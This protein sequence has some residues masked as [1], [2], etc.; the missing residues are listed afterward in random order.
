MSEDEKLLFIKHLHK[1]IKKRKK[2]KT[3]K[4][5]P[6]QKRF[7]VMGFSLFGLASCFP[8]EKTKHFCKLFRVRASAKR[9]NASPE[10]I[11]NTDIG[12]VMKKRA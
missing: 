10:N 6:V 9:C 2:E 1:Q 4:L 5:A 3:P 11:K 12:G 8:I 7:S